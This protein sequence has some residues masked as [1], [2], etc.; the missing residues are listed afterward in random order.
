MVGNDDWGPPIMGGI[1]RSD[2]GPK[3]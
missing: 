2:V 3:R 1:L